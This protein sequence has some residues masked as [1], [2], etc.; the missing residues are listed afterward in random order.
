MFL[1]H[2]RRINEKINLRLSVLYSLVFILSSGLLFVVIFFFLSSAL[3]KEDQTA[4]HLK[5]LELWA[6]YET[7]GIE[8]QIPKNFRSCHDSVY[9][10]QF[11]RWCITRSTFL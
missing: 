1:R 11:C 7:G 2:L 3:R 8:T 5:L 10:A 4:M 6:S 9:P